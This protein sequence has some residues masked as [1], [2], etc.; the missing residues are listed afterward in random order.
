MLEKIKELRHCKSE[1][2]VIALGLIVIILIGGFAVSRDGLGKSVQ[3]ADN[4]TTA[5]QAMK[6]VQKDA[7]ATYEYVGQ[8]KAKDQVKVMSKVSGNI[9]DKMVD[10]GEYVAKGQPLFKIDNKQYESAI[11]SAQAALAKAE[12]THRS[13]ERTAMRYSALYKLDAAARETTDSYIAQA[14]EDASTVE[15]SRSA[16]QE[17]LDNEKDTTIISPIDGRI[18]INDVSSGYYVVAGSTVMA[19]VSSVDPVWVQFTMSESEYLDLLL[20]GNDHLPDFFR[21]HLQ[22]KLSNGGTYPI[23]GHVDQLD[24]AISETTGTITLKATF[25]NPNHMLAPGMFAKLIVHGDV[26]KN[27]LMIPQKAVK[28]VLNKSIVYVVAAGNKAESRQVTLGN[29]VGDMVII[30]EGLSADD[31]VVVEG[32]DKIKKG[33]PLSITMVEAS[34]GE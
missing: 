17:A 33:S 19:T 14:E 31:T 22:I 4:Q 8:V 12:T 13:S 23:E 15:T 10:G 29:K 1:K 11:R 20:L 28:D 7:S 26:Q 27:A 5:V 16:L 32:I 25:E 9:I 6:V 30:T 21:D 34:E 18:D 24:N 2:R 3:N